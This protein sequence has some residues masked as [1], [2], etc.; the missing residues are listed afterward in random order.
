[1]PLVLALIDVALG[2]HL[3]ERFFH[4]GLV[5]GIGGADVAVVAD[6]ELV[7]EVFKLGADGVGVLFGALVP[8]RRRLLD[9]LAVLVGAGEE[10]R[11]LPLQRVVARQHVG[12]HRRVGVADMRHVV[13][14]VDRCG[15]IKLLG[16]S[17]SSPK[18]QRLK[19]ESAG[20]ALTHA[21]VDR[22]HILFAQLAAEK[23]V[24]PAAAL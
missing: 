5:V 4:P 14:I 2:Q 15:H 22:I 17:F 11:L 13:D 16:H 7:P 21:G 12:D 6:A 1:M 24:A 20:L 18:P 19:L 3:L 8:S 10:E 23:P 9:L